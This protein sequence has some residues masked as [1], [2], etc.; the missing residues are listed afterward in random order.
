[1][2]LLFVTEYSPFAVLSILSARASLLSGRLP[3]RNG[4]Y[5]SQHAR[6]CTYVSIS[7]S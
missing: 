3:V 7:K 1:M 5:S 2:A 4:F 6:N